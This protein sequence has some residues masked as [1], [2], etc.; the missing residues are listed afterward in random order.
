[1]TV[2]LEDVDGRRTGDDDV[3]DRLDR[4]PADQ[5]VVPGL[6]LVGDTTD[7]DEPLEIAA[8][9]EH[10]GFLEEGADAG[11]GGALG[12]GEVDGGAGGDQVGLGGVPGGEIG[13]ARRR[14][15]DEEGG[16]GDGCQRSQDPG[17]DDAWWARRR[18][19]PVSGGHLGVPDVLGS[20]VAGVLEVGALGRW[21]L[22][23]GRTGHGCSLRLASSQLCR[24]TA[25]ATLSRTCPAGV[26]AHVG[27]E[28]RRFGEHGGESLVMELHR[29]LHL[30]GRRSLPA[31]SLGGRPVLPH[32][33]ATPGDLPP[34][35]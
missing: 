14:P 20:E 34:P 8:V 28:Q 29:H 30:P 35:W 32:R 1:M 10:P 27:L 16:H 4:H 2:R 23:V 7:Q 6:E 13:E 26:A 22:V 31:P 19:W 24:I 5:V 17:G 33:T 11:G 3:G 21:R 25:A 9:G 18:W 12:H 15:S